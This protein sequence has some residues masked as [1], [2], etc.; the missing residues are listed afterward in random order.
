VCGPGR[1]TCTPHDGRRG[2]VCVLGVFEPATG[3]A[4]ILYS[5]RRDSA[6]FVQLLELVLQ[7]YAAR[8]WVLISDNLTIQLSCETQT[9]LL[10]WPEVQLLWLPKYACWLNPIEPWW[11]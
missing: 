6:S 4:M 1:A 9:A 3:L 10:A 11:E 5:P 7:M 2:T 8:Q